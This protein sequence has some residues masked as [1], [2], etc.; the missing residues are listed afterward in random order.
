MTLAEF[1]EAPPRLPGSF[2][3]A[4]VDLNGHESL[5][6]VALDEAMLCRVQKSYDGCWCWVEL[7]VGVDGVKRGITAQMVRDVLAHTHQH[8]HAP[9]PPAS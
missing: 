3:L 8:H 5:R 4:I 2:P 1:I 9:K 7:D 6:P